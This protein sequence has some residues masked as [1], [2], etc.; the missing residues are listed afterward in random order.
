MKV[1]ADNLVK[2]F[3]NTTQKSYKDVPSNWKRSTVSLSY[4]KKQ[5]AAMDICRNMGLK[6]QCLNISYI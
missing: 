6:G 4:K 3:F 5:N 1:S 2:Y